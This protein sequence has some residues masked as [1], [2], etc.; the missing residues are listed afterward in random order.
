M[1]TIDPQ[2]FGAGPI[3]IFLGLGGVRV[4]PR[5]YIGDTQ[6]G[7]GLHNMVLAVVNAALRERAGRRAERIAVTLSTDGSCTVSDDGPGLSGEPDGRGGL[8]EIEAVMTQFVEREIA[9]NAEQAALCVVNALSHWLRIETR[10]LGKVYDL[11]FRHGV[12]LSPLGVRDA[13]GDHRGTD[14]SFRPSADIFA[15]RIFDVARLGDRFDALSRQ[16]GAQI[17]LIDARGT[18]DA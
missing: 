17:S 11:E 4:R 13:E 15:E 12:P 14:I 8:R 10:S 3:R 18:R 5:M 7:T 6:D 9:S 16:T 1:T 2:S